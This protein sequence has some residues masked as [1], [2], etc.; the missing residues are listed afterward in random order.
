MDPNLSHRLI[1]QHPPMV[2]APITNR[3]NLNRKWWKIFLISTGKTPGDLYRERRCHAIISHIL[4]QWGCLFSSHSPQWHRLSCRL[5]YFIEKFLKR[6]LGTFASSLTGLSDISIFFAIIFT[7]EL[8]IFGGIHTGP[9]CAI[10]IF[11]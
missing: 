7:Y 1:L 11:I 8:V 2:T 10:K 3:D 9:T 6:S 5:Y 4:A